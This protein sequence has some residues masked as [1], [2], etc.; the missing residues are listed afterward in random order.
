M[1]SKKVIVIEGGVE[2]KM[3]KLKPSSKLMAVSLMPK[4]CCIGSTSRLSTRR[5]VKADINPRLSTP[6]TYQR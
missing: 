6:I 1:E 4:S 2:K 3:A 5:S